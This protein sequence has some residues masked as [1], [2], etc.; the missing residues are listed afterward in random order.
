MFQRCFNGVVNSFS[1][2]LTTNTASKRAGLVLLAFSLTPCMTIRL[3]EME[4]LLPALVASSTRA[5]QYSIGNPLI[6]NKI[7]ASD[8]LGALYAPARVLIY[9]REGKTWISYDRPST[10]FG[11]LGSNEVL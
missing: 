4:R 6:A 7:A 3:V 9:T 1:L 11:R 2:V 8:T 10:V 5:R